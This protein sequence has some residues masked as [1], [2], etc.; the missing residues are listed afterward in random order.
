[1]TLVSQP[2]PAYA[3]GPNDWITEALATSNQGGKGV[4]VF[5]VRHY[6]STPRDKGSWIYVHSD[7]L[8]GT[9]GGGEVERVVEAAAHDMLAG[10]RIWGRVYEKF[11]LGPDM[12]QCCGGGMEVVFEPVDSTSINWLADALNYVNQHQA[13]FVVIDWNDTLKAPIV[14]RSEASEKLIEAEGVHMQSIIDRRPSLVIYGAGH[15]ARAFAA[16]AAQLP[17]RLVI[18]DER[19]NELN[20][21]PTAPNIMPVFMEYPPSH[22]AQLDASIE[23]VLVMTYSHALDYRLC[24]SL[25]KNVELNYI[26]LIGSKS[27]GARFRRRFELDDG[28]S[29]VQI[30]KLVSP[31]GQ[32][33]VRGKEPGMIALATLNEVMAVLEETVP[34]DQSL[35][36]ENF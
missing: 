36:V 10:R 4:L 2:I 3:L 28:L 34:M 11:M 24:L 7:Q 8:L 5:V 25:L 9:L 21:V 1:M 20:L 30:S 17:I 26:G 16:I 23:A 13:G 27:K 33:G 18:V 6:G 22:A 12:G 31:I 14:H 32:G 35:R 29:A 15:V 19:Q